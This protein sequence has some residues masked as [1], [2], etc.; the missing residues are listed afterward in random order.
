MALLSSESTHDLVG[1]DPDISLTTV[2]C[3]FFFCHF[4]II[5]SVDDCC[6]N[7]CACVGSTVV[8]Y[9]SKLCIYDIIRTG[10]GPNILL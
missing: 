2:I 5:N 9:F 10:C 4:V 6:N 3:Q 7:C 1:D 8:H